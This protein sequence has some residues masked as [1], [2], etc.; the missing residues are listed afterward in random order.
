MSPI[1]H[2]ITRILSKF[3]V[4]RCKIES[5]IFGTDFAYLNACNTCVRQAL[6][7]DLQICSL[8]KTPVANKAQIKNLGTSYFIQLLLVKNNTLM[9]NLTYRLFLTKQ[10]C[11][12][13]A[14]EVM[15]RGGGPAIVSKDHDLF[16]VSQKSL[17]DSVVTTT[18]LSSF[19]YIKR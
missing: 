19:L 14:S 11:G 9:I 7:N 15:G 8:W 18:I 6:K 4:I 13:K 12:S 2:D 3:G 10:K 17:K 5:E 1:L 16:T